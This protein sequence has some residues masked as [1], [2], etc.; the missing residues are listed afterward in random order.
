MVATVVASQSLCEALFPR[1][2]MYSIKS[3]AFNAGVLASNP[4]SRDL[5]ILS[6][7]L[8]LHGKRLVED[9]TLELSVNFYLLPL[10]HDHN[11]FRENGGGGR[12]VSVGLPP[13]PLGM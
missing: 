4:L 5:K 8:S 7:S 11:H 13:V 9:T 3:F 1:S 6:F 12:C 10:S 2:S